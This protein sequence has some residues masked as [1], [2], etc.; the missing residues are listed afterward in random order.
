MI[1]F[2]QV[3]YDDFVDGRVIFIGTND[4]ATDIANSFAQHGLTRDMLTVAHHPYEEGLR[5]IGY[6]PEWHP[7]DEVITPDSISELIALDWGAAVKLVND[8]ENRDIEWFI[9]E[10]IRGRAYININPFEDDI[11]DIRDMICDAVSKS[12]I[13]ISEDYNEDPCIYWDRLM[14]DCFRNLFVDTTDEECLNARTHTGIGSG[15]RYED[16]DGSAVFPVAYLA[17]KLA[18]NTDNI[19]YTEDDFS[20][21]F[22]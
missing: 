12:N 8:L 20:D 18:S 19:V 15:N 17:K 6:A 5:F 11:S 7:D 21:I 2:A 14:P 22:N 1:N 10:F 16:I 3:L 4:D 9:N 13:G